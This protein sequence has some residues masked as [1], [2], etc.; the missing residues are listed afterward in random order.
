MLSEAMLS[1]S[2]AGVNPET[3]ICE[4]AQSGRGLSFKHLLADPKSNQIKVTADTN[5]KQVNRNTCQKSQS[6]TLDTQVITKRQAMQK[7]TSKETKTKTLH[8]PWSPVL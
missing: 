1:S 7:Q 8:S 4:S 3:P 2:W 6:T 5:Q